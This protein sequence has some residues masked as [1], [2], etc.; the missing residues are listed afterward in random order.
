MGLIKLPIEGLTF[1]LA[2]TILAAMLGMLQ[3]GYNTGVINAP[4][5]NIEKFMRDVY[6][7]RN[8]K[9]LP[10]DSAK[11]MYSFVVSIFA[12]GGMIGGFSGGMVANRF[13]RKGGL[14]L[15]NVLGI[16]GACLMAFTKVC[17][18]YEMLLFGR[19]I[20][21]VNCGLNTSLVPMYISEIA[22]LNLRGGLGTVNQLAVTTGMLISQILGIDEILGT[23]DG[24]PVL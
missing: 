10:E 18:S 16:G 19:F 24:W 6:K 4:E 20:I 13:G 22:P 8:K 3:F 12:I 23:D 2:Y 17:S 1:F 14:L 5:N 21:G 15:N 9:D 7:D 11:L